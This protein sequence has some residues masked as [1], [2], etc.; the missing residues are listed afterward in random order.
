[1]ALHDVSVPLH[2]GM[3]I[4]RDNPGSRSS[5]HSSIADGAGANVSKLTMGCHTGTHID[6]PMHFYDDGAGADALPL[7]A[8]IGRR[9]R[10]RASR[11]RRSGRSAPPRSSRSASRRAPSA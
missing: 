2:P 1:M 9:A 10:R 6:G 11:H 5:S 3:V 8:M 4:Y 7:D